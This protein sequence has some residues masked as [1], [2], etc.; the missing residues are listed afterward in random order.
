VTGRRISVSVSFPPIPAI[1]AAGKYR[2]RAP[3]INYAQI[4]KLHGQGISP[5]EI[6]KL[7]G[8]GRTSV[9]RALSAA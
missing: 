5:S 7:S 1:I 6:G 4:K 3:T 9:Y 8:V 2:G